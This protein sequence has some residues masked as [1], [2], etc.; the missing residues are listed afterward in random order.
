MPHSILSDFIR[1]SV[2]LAKVLNYQNLFSFKSG[3]GRENAGN[4][5][6][7][8]QKA[9]RLCLQGH[10]NEQTPVSSAQSWLPSG[11]F[12]RLL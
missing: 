7:W 2:A 9:R 6:G 5:G 1:A 10:L 4:S 12:L 8:L 3:M 11:G